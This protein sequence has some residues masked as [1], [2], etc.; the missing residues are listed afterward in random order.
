MDP[1]AVQSPESFDAEKEKTRPTQPAKKK[2]SESKH[3][4]AGE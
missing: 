3:A 4:A 2:E 1:E